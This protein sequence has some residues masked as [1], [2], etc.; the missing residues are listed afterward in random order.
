M[1]GRRHEI[2]RSPRLR[3]VLRRSGAGMAAETAV[4]PSRLGRYPNVAVHNKGTFE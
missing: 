4:G 1:R 2:G 3:A